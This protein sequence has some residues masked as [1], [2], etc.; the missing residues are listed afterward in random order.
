MS[1]LAPAARRSASRRETPSVE[2][3]MPGGRLILFIR[4]LFFC[5]KINFNWKSNKNSTPDYSIRESVVV[6]AT[7]REVSLTLSH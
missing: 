1:A 7:S 2:L 6:F 5:G 4:F 3:P